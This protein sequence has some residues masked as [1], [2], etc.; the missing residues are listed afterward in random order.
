MGTRSGALWREKLM[1]AVRLTASANRS[2]VVA[3]LSIAWSQSHPWHSRLALLGDSLLV[4]P[5][6]KCR[7][8][9]RSKIGRLMH[10]R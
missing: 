10:A 7:C 6:A 4:R 9:P 1:W 8:A 5:T 2:T 3:S